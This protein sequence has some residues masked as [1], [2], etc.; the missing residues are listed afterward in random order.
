MMKSKL[1]NVTINKNYKA[2]ALEMKSVLII[3]DVQMVN[4]GD[5]V[6]YLMDRFL[7]MLWCVKE[8]L[9]IQLYKMI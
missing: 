8:G 3:W 9:L 1:K 7:I 4:A 2:H 6:E 5:M